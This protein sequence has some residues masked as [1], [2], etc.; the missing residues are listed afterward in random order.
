M[1][2][3]A[4]RPQFDD[5]GAAVIMTEQRNREAYMRLGQGHDVVESRLRSSLPEHLNSEIVA[6]TIGD[7]AQ[8]RC[9][10][11]RC[12]DARADLISAQ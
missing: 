8:A 4:G 7:V 9:C 1:V 3:R 6:G 5:F 2:G 12:D 11:F 10:C